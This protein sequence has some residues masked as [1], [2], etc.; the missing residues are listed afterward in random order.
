VHGTAEVTPLVPLVVHGTAEVT[1]PVVHGTA[2]VTPP[3]V[4]LVA[5]GTGH[6]LLPVSSCDCFRAYFGQS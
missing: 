2:E 3:V 1:P 5:H 6:A 4:V